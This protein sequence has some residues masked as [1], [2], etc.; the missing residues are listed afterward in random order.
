MSTFLVH[1]LQTDLL[2]TDPCGLSNNSLVSQEI[3]KV[4]DRL[5]AL[6]NDLGKKDPQVIS[7]KKYYTLLEIKDY[8]YYKN[9]NEKCKTNFVL[10]LFFYSNDPKKCEKCEDQGFVLSYVRL[11]NQ[12]IRTYSFDVDLGVSIL[13]YLV[14]HYNITELPSVVFNEKTHKGFLDRADVEEMLNEH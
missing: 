12:N 7:L 10:N 2:I 8:L 1:N 6:E 9:L 13:D 4:G 5:S 14:K 11:K 3:F